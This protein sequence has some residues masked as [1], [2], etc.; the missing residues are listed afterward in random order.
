MNLSSR[1]HILAVGVAL[2]LSGVGGASAAD[3]RPA[4]S[5]Q[6]VDARHEAQIL[7]SFDM[8]RH[9]RGYPLTVAADGSKVVLEGKVESG[10]AKDLAGDIANGVE[11]IKQVDNRI[12][13][14][15]DVTV[16]T[17]AKD[18]RSFGDRVD[19][20]NVTASVKSKLLWNSHTDGLDIHVET[21]HGKVTLTGQADSAAE[22]DLAGRIARDTNGVRAVDNKL[23][24]NAA[25]A[26][27]AAKAKPAPAAA[28]RPVSDGWITAKVKSSLVYTR[29]VEAFDITVTTKDGVVTLDGIVETAAERDLAIQVARDVRGVKK[30]VATGIK[31][32]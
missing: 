23:A 13:V 1:K 7:T 9:L 2:A 12:V 22:R 32:G 24:L 31:L 20:S 5:Q 6:V 8:N 19:D 25:G 26:T 11:G 28:D 16:A 21:S 27:T 18:D 17:R 15:P 10:V 30:V 29:K 4:P 14:D 3:P